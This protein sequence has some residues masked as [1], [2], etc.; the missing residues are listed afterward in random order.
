MS[1]TKNL[2]VTIEEA[3]HQKEPQVWDTE[4]EPRDKK[5][6]KA[7]NGFHTLWEAKFEGEGE[8]KGRVALNKSVAF[9]KFVMA[10]VRILLDF[11]KLI[12]RRMH[13]TWETSLVS[14]P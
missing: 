8:I 3:E 9:L 14:A 13:K 6:R 2:Q 5:Q 11:L 12:L 10:E 1:L 4:K 7:L